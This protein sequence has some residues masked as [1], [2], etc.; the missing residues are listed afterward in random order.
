M[1][2]YVFNYYRMGAN[3]LLNY[4]AGG[5]HLL[6]WRGLGMPKID[7]PGMRAPYT[8]GLIPLNAAT[9]TWPPSLVAPQVVPV[10]Y[11]PPREV[12][13]AIGMSAASASAFQ[14]E[15]AAFIA[16][17]SPYGQL[18][19]YQPSFLKITL[20]DGSTYRVLTCFCTEVSAPEMDGPAYGV[21][22]STFYAPDPYF[23]LQ[24]GTA[25]T[26]YDTTW[27]TG[28]NPKTI[29]NPG[30]APVWPVIQVFGAAGETI[31]GLHLTNTTTGAIWSTSQTIAIGATKY[32][33][34]FMDRAQMDYYNDA[35]HTDI[36]STLDTDA[37]F[38]LLQKGDNV[39]QWSSTS[40][41]PSSITVTHIWR[42]LGI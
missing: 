12:E 5:R 18:N 15:Y 14:T 29:T 26:P 21:I 10:P 19:D 38:W 2:G 36:I 3:Y 30:D 9:P 4:P 7:I 34:V 13:I 20:P 41:T 24:W 33:R 16:A 22:T 42:Y 27:A 11:V 37:E 39:L 1:A 31:V 35:T 23:T 6:G 25:G 32:I 40:G 28:T 17:M 8:D